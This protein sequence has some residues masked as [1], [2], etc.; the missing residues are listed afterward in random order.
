VVRTGRARWVLAVAGAAFLAPAAGAAPGPVPGD[1]R[2][3]PSGATAAGPLAEAAAALADFRPE[4]AVRILERART[5]G[6]F[7]HADHLRLYEQLGIAQAYLDRGKEALEAFRFLLALAPGHAISYTLSPK[8]TFVFEQARKMAA[9]AAQPA[10]D[11]GWPRGLEVGQG[12]PVDVEVLADPERFLARAELR[13]R[14]RG[15]GAPF[16]REVFPLP[17][18][19]E[20]AVRVTLPAVE[21]RG[22][23]AEVVEFYLVASDARGNEVLVFGSEKRPREIVLGASPPAPWYGRWWVWT[24]VGV[25][26]AGGATAAG[27]ATRDPDPTV[28]GV[29]RVER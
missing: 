24:L 17:R 15:S 16:A 7:A 18:A 26:V 28:D 20:P 19:G 27:L 21:P 25:A 13:H 10:I 4:D 14:L 23:R 6:P 29:F 2:Q 9:E 5:E 3:A 12:V 8:V 11:L 1:A 22:A